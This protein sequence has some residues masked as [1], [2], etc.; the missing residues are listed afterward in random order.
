MT[1]ALPIK[2]GAWLA[3]YLAIFTV[4]S[5]ALFVVIGGLLE[6]Y[7]F[8][9][10]LWQWPVYAWNF[11]DDPDVSPWLLGTGIPAAV[12]PLFVASLLF[13]R[14]SRRIRGWTLRQDFPT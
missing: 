3:A 10:M 14:R 5:S 9:D 8:P 6:T 12:L 13:W 1:R 2:I 4:L 11:G 7:P